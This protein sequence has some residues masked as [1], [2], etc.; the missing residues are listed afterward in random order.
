M[1]KMIK[2]RSPLRISFAGGGTDLPP[3][4]HEKGGLVVSA[5][6]GKYAYATLTPRDDKEIHIE[7]VDFLKSVKFDDCSQLD[8]NQELDVLKAVIKHLNPY[9]RGLN[10]WMRNDVPPRSGLGASAAAFSAMIGLFNHILAERGMTKYQI[11]DLAFKL[12]REELGIAG[13]YQD[14]YATV[15]G[16]F[17]YIE[18]DKSGVRVEPIPLKDESIFELEKQLVL[19]YAKDRPIQGGVI[20]AEKKAYKEN[21]A[22]AA[23]LDHTKELAKEIRYS[24]IK[25]DFGRFGEILHEAWQSKKKH[26]SLVSDA[27]IDELYDTA[28]KQGAIGGKISG[29]GGGGF[30]FFLC[31]HNTEH[32]VRE[33]LEHMGAK[34]VPFTFDR[35]GLKTWEIL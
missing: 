5:S 2:S 18:V 8:Y 9:D 34:S 26:S 29:A 28:I 30:M 1:F 35:D 17:N 22:A 15:F 7:S 11:A 14:Q 4:C 20:E 33:A 23:A 21:K 10:I 6:I 3:Y 16:G 31:R 32:K 13:G 25:S 12:E 19:I 24:L 27:F